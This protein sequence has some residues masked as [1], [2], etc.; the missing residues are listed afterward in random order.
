M[1]L[2]DYSL[3]QSQNTQTKSYRFRQRTVWRSAR[4]LTL[5]VVVS[6]PA[7]AA[8]DLDELLSFCARQNLNMPDAPSFQDQVVL[9]DPGPL[10]SPGCN[11]TCFDLL[12]AGVRAVVEKV[13][14][15]RQYTRLASSSGV[16]RYSLST[17]DDPK[18]RNFIRWSAA[19]LKPGKRH[20][21]FEEKCI[22]SE[23]GS[24]EEA[25][26]NLSFLYD[27]FKK[28]DYF[29]SVQDIQIADSHSK[30]K[31]TEQRIVSYSTI[32]AKGNKSSNMCTKDDPRSVL[33]Q[34]LGR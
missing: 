9:L 18:C 2:L 19:Y 1:S 17:Y 7:K 25:S 24:I 29:V 33:N 15:L 3:C 30:M 13:P 11:P 8:S 23:F 26:F 14:Q 5:L 16:W 6:F 10:A 12:K 22:A 31:I 21:G 32:D 34:V 4:I 20:S 28:G 27:T